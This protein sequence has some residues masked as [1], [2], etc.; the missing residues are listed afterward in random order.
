MNTD[1]AISVLSSMLSSEDSF[2]TLMDMI[3]DMD[4]E[5][6]DINLL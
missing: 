2:S 5:L 4:L 3:N 6:R 1:N